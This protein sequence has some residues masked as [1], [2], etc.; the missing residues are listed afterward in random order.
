MIFVVR[1]SIFDGFSGIGE[2][3]LAILKESRELWQNYLPENQREPAE[4]E[5]ARL[6][7]D[8]FA[9]RLGEVEKRALE[10]FVDFLLDEKRI[11]RGLTVE[12][13]IHPDFMGG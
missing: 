3:L 7:W 10:T 12:D 11:S 5:L 9:Y 1:E 13:L 2:V 6:G 8:P 4:T